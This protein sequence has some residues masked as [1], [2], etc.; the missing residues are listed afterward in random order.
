MEYHHQNKWM[1]SRRTRVKRVVV[2]TVL[3]SLLFSEKVIKNIYC[4]AETLALA[5]GIAHNGKKE[6]SN[7]P[8]FI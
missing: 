4:E 1:G 7:G 5:A 3:L 8:L 2:S 6:G